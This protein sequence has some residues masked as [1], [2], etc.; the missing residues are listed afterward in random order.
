MLKQPEINFDHKLE[1][2]KRI[3]FLEK[4][5]QPLLEAN[6]LTYWAHRLRHFIGSLRYDRNED[7]GNFEAEMAR[8]GRV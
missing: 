7:L 5:S 1:L 3:K 6:F 4:S 8:R 2:Y